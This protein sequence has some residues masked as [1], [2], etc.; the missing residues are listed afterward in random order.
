MSPSN[1]YPQIVALAG[2][3]RKGAFQSMGPAV[4]RATRVVIADDRARSREGLRALLGTQA[5]IE[6]VGIARD[7]QE[8]LALVGRLQPDTVLMDA[9][10]PQMDGLA[11]TRHIKAEWPAVRVIVLTIYASLKDTAIASGADGFV[12]KGCL[13]DELLEAIH[14]A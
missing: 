8:A 10:M 12:I 7:G 9:R 13:P 1:G 5:G 2:P 3:S 6:I 4:G 11:A 14:G